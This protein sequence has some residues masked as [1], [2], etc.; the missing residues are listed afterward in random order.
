[1]G[2]PTVLKRPLH[3]RKNT[4][5]IFAFFPWHFKT[6][7]YRHKEVFKALSSFLRIKTEC[8][9]LTLYSSLL[10]LKYQGHEFCADNT[11]IIADANG[12]FNFD[13]VTP[14]DYTVEEV[15][16]TDYV[17]VS[18]EDTSDDELDHIN[19]IEKIIY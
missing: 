8:F 1:M 4:A 12:E 3:P 6:N 7:Y 2:A 9:K 17:S 11:S 19:I 13:D 14:G 18:D 15:D 5:N 10:K 16:P